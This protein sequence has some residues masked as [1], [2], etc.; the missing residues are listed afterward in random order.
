MVRKRRTARKMREPPMGFSCRCSQLAMSV[1]KDFLLLQLGLGTQ[2]G[3]GL[4]IWYQGPALSGESTGSFFTPVMFVVQHVTKV[5][6]AVTRHRGGHGN[7]H[8]HRQGHAKVS[9]RASRDR[10]QAR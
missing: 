2:Q 7:G 8:G 5:L 6:Q 3:A 1:V 10:V 9:N 4:M